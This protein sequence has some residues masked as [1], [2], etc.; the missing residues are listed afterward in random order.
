MDYINFGTAG[1]KVSPVALGLGLRGQGSEA[2][3]AR[4][5]EH[6]LAQGINLIDCA[7]VYSTLDDHSHPGVSE[8]ILGRVLKGRRGEVVITSKV[9]G[10]IGPGPNDQGR[11]IDPLGLPRPPVI[12]S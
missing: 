4:L 5:I 2:E 6:A 3:A 12:I 8:T 7:N 9:A 10:P 11:R 1:L